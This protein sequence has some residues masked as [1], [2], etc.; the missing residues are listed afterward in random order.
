MSEDE[1]PGHVRAALVPVIARIVAGDFAGL[2]ADGLAPRHFG[3]DLGVWVREYPFE[4]VDLPDE[5][6]RYADAFA[7]GDGAWAVCVPLWT[8]EEG[9][10]DLTVEATVTEGPDGP[11]VEVDDIHVL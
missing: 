1:V 3:D 8:A 7:I 5:G 11:R 4:P 9:R 6:W 2:V 10:S